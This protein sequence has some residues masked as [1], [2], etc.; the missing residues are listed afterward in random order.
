MEQMVATIVQIHANHSK[1]NDEGAI[2]SHHLVYWRYLVQIL[3]AIEW[4][5]F[6][7]LLLLWL[8]L[9]SFVAISTS[10]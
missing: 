7:L 10:L 4:H 8:L 3:E 1:G 2:V 5:S 9:I 6:P